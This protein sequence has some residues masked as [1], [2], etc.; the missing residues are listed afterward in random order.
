MS[1]E[2]MSTLERCNAKEG[3]NG[4]GAPRDTERQKPRSRDGNSAVRRRRTG[5][6]SKPS[7]PPQSTRPRSLHGRG[8]LGEGPALSTPHFRC[9][10]SCPFYK[11]CLTHSPAPPP[12][13]LASPGSKSRN[14]MPPG[15]AMVGWG[16]EG[17]W[18]TEV[19]RNSG[20]SR[21]AAIAD[22]TLLVA[23]Q[24]ASCVSGRKRGGRSL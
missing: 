19:L 21:E 18:S 10:P 17:F 6:H 9:H 15:G 22:V 3:P 16:R 12:R 4:R 1:S 13:P 23:R 2:V 5:G 11:T 7:F 20:G 14:R 24:S 8:V